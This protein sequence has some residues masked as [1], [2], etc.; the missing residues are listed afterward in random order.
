MAKNSRPDFSNWDDERRILENKVADLEAEISRLRVKL[1]SV[2]QNGESS[3]PANS[4]NQK[5]SHLQALHAQEIQE[6]LNKF[7]QEKNASAEIFKSSLKAQVSSLIP[8]IK[9]QYKVA[10]RD[11]LVRIREETRQKARAHYQGI[12]ES[13]KV[14]MAE[15]RRV[16]ERLFKQKLEEERRQWQ[17]LMRNK[18]EAKMARLKND[19]DREFLNKYNV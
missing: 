13:M 17:Q 2:R 16:S 4:S 6:L 10:Y 11:A 14:E 5:I 15:E 12:I 18:F 7:E 9:D 19:I 1:R 3:S 8:K